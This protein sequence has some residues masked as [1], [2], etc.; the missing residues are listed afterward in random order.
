MP[1]DG[2]GGALCDGQAAGRCHRMEWEELSVKDRL[3]LQA[4]SPAPPERCNEGRNVTSWTRW[5]LHLSI[6]Q[7]P[8]NHLCTVYSALCWSQPP[9]TSC[10]QRLQGQLCSRPPPGRPGH[11]VVTQSCTCLVPEAVRLNEGWQTRGA[12]TGRSSDTRPRAAGGRVLLG[13]VLGSVGT[14]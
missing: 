11:S 13:C 10:P 5:H 3:H 4:R 12:G 14:N 6:L 1:Q 8:A 9:P 2:V 7:H